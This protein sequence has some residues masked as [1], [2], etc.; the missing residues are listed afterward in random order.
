MAV[1]FAPGARPLGTVKG[2]SHR[3]SHTLGTVGLWRFVV[4]PDAAN[5]VLRHRDA[6]PTLFQGAIEKIPFK[7]PMKICVGRPWASVHF[8]KAVAGLIRCRCSGRRRSYT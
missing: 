5:T 3:D 8:S 6:L 4:Y 7:T 2:L 1:F